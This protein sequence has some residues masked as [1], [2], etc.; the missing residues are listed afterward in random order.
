MP[1]T[2]LISS[3]TVCLVFEQLPPNEASFKYL[4]Y[5]ACVCKTWLGC[6]TVTRNNASWLVPFVKR[7]RDYCSTLKKARET[8]DFDIFLRG[9]RDFFSDENVQ[10]DIMINIRAPL[11]DSVEHHFELMDAFEKCPVE[12][13]I[14]LMAKIVK[15]YIHSEAI[16]SGVCKIIGILKIIDTL[17]EMTLRTDVLL[18]ANLMPLLMEGMLIHKNAANQEEGEMIFQAVMSINWPDMDCLEV[19]IEYMMSFPNSRPIVK[20]TLLFINSRINADKVRLLQGTVLEQIV[21][22]A[23]LYSD[24]EMISGSCFHIFECIIQENPDALQRILEEDCIEVIGTILDQQAYFRSSNQ[25]YCLVKAIATVP[26][27]SAKLHETGIIRHMVASADFSDPAVCATLLAVL[28]DVVENDNN[29]LAQALLDYGA[30]ALVKNTLRT[31]KNLDSVYCA[32]LGFIAVASRHECFKAQVIDRQLLQSLCTGFG[33]HKE[34][35]QLLPGIIKGLSALL[36]NN[37]PM[38]CSSV[39]DKLLGGIRGVMSKYTESLEVQK[40]CCHFILL[41]HEKDAQ[42]RVCATDINSIEL[43]LYAVNKHDDDMLHIAALQYLTVMMTV[44][45]YRAHMIKKKAVLV[46]LATL[47]CSSKPQCIE[48]CLLFLSMLKREDCD[49]VKIENMIS[50]MPPAEKKQALDNVKSAVSLIKMWVQ[51]PTVTPRMHEFAKAISLT[52]LL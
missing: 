50:C 20:H 45:D 14:P 47:K 46:V 33:W 21:H 24:D 29:D 8:Q 22:V 12:T 15:K 34:Q 26:R 51:G 31:H 41:A 6:S 23:D 42:N 40:E 5:L 2:V 44:D 18:A 3:D 7:G 16:F 30:M 11:S 43:V 39:T 9:M 13:L 1:A 35:P 28:T 49:M 25:I 10:K 37:N 27:Y 17:N 48:L 38:T 19:V 4:T 32:A 52:F 36:E